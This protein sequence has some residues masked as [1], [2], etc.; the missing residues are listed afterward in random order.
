MLYS[1][2][3]HKA[4]KHFCMFCLQ[5]F[6]S[7]EVL[8]K[9]KG[10]CVQVNGAQA[11]RMPAEGSKV[12]F[13]NHH[14]QLPAPFVIYTDFEAILKKSTEPG[15][16][17]E[18]GSYTRKYQD[19]KACGYG[20]KVVCQYGKSF[21][22]PYE[23][24]PGAVKHFMN[25]MLKEVTKCNEVVKTHF[26]KSM[27]KLSR[28]QRD[29]FERSTV[30]HICR[31]KFRDEEK[32]RDHCHVT[33]KYRGAAHSSCNLNF[34]LTKKIPVVFHNLRGYDSHLIMQEIGSFKGNTN[35]I[36]TNME[37]YLSFTLGNQ[38]VFIDSIQFMSSSLGALVDNLPEDQLRHLSES[39]SGEELMLVS[40]KGVY[41]Y[42]HMD[43][44]SRFDER[45]L[46]PKGSFYSSLNDSNISDEDYAHAHNVW[47]T[48]EMETMKEYH[49]LYLKTD[50]LLLADVFESFR[51]SCLKNYKLDPAHY[52]SAPGLSWEPC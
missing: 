32:V 52:I 15:V 44:F 3:A 38:L 39:F 4:K 47:N 5:G 48:F 30:C 24:G 41:P 21:S 7:E 20:Y 45:Q 6:P 31:E 49:D 11:I 10:V 28:K 8:E 34:K 27:G 18:E 25:K 12:K 42:E 26:N 36:A 17:G 29:A 37:K 9:H 2:T 1:T 16:G 35:V 14:K 22:R 13:G 43:S 40:R 33:G 46:P 23:S 51:K 19:H 50:V